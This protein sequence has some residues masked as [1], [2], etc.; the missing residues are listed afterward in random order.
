[1]PRFIEARP[2]TEYLQKR[3]VVV[4]EFNGWCSGIADVE[5]TTEELDDGVFFHSGWGCEEVAMAFNGGFI[6]LNRVSTQ[7][8]AFADGAAALRLAQK[9]AM[10]ETPATVISFIFSRQFKQVSN[11]LDKRARAAMA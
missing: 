11:R 2:N 4:V 10:P 1:I 6:D 7:T 9:A 3:I 8:F 5:G